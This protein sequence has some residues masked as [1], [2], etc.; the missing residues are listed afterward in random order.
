MSKRKNNITFT[1]PEDPSFLKRMKE[2]IG[3]KEG[4]SVDTKVF[5]KFFFVF[6]RFMYN[7]P[8]CRNK[9]KSSTIQRTKIF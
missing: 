1:R 7:F 4:P 3:Y 9:K 8:N 2:Q 5:I 6:N